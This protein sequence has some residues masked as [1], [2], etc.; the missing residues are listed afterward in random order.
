M[1]EFTFLEARARRDRDIERETRRTRWRLSGDSHRAEVVGA[2]SIEASPDPSDRIFDDA[3]AGRAH[4][5]V[6]RCV[7]ADASKTRGRILQPIL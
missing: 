2:L 5:E 3:R 1:V 4:E 7:M 6:I